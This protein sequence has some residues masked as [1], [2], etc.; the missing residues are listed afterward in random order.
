MIS[1]TK[2]K[3]Q[4]LISDDECK[5]CRTCISGFHRKNRLYCGIY[6]FSVSPKHV[7]RRWVDKSL[8]ELERN[9]RLEEQRKLA[10]QEKDAAPKVEVKQYAETP[11]YKL[12]EF[13]KSK[14]LTRAEVSHLIGIGLSTIK[15]IE[16][17]D[18][19]IPPQE[20]TIQKL[21][22]FYPSELIMTL[23]KMGER[24]RVKYVSSYEVM[25]KLRSLIIK[26]HPDRH[27]EVPHEIISDLNALKDKIG[28]EL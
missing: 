2:E 6:Y 15:N 18:Y 28:K 16:T 22:R 27:P 11:F 7:C 20:K 14:N 8:I 21:S 10:Q 3:I 23:P 26:W 24:S 4:Y 17:G 5:T 25:R 1:K 19:K 13:R 12:E 9:K